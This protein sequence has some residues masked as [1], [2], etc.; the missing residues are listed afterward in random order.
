MALT[1]RKVLRVYKVKKEIRVIREF[2]VWQ[3]PMEL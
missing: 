2:R 1:A 3:V